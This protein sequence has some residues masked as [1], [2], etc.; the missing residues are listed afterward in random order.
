MPL[1]RVFA[2]FLFA[3]QRFFYPLL[4]FSIASADSILVWNNNSPASPMTRSAKPIFATLCSDLLQPCAL[5]SDNISSPSRITPTTT[6]NVNAVSYRRQMV[7]LSD[8]RLRALPQ[9]LHRRHH[10]QHL[11][12]G[13]RGPPPALRLDSRKP[14]PAAPLP[15]QYEFAR[16]ILT[17]T[18]MTKRKLMQLV[19]EHS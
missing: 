16:L 18:I 9:R 17:Y 14:Q 1:F 4:S 13:I 6:S 3:R 19:N 8:V 12:A 10:A 5:I 2:Q 7:H 11:H 15:H